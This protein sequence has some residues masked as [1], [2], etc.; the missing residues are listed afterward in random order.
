M[1]IKILSLVFFIL[2]LTMSFAFGQKPAGEYFFELRGKVVD[3]EKVPYGAMSLNFAGENFKGAALSDQDGNF[4]IKL[5]VGKFKVTTN[6][7]NSTTFTAFIEIFENGLNPTNFELIVDLNKNWCTNC[8]EGKMPETVKHVAPLYPPTARAVGASGEVVVAIKIDKDG[9]VTGAQAVSG[10]P[11]LRQIAAQAARQ[12]LFSTDEAMP[13]R[14]GKLVF[15]FIK[16]FK[17][18]PANLLRKPNR[19][20]VFSRSETIQY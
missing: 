18:E 14:E 20:E 17:T 13:E 12:W 6:E 16:S 8:P 9:V 3:A 19:L 5:P 15:V 4:S 1:Q 2:V 7:V 11:L 10:H